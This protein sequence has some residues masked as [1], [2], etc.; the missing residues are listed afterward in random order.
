MVVRFITPDHRV[1]EADKDI[2][3]RLV[4]GAPQRRM[5]PMMEGPPLPMSLPENCPL[6]PP[7]S[8]THTTQWRPLEAQRPVSI[9]RPLVIE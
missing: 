5:E 9:G 6:P 4:P 7:T 2:K 3:V 1:Y 8:T